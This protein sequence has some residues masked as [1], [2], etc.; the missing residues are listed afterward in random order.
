MKKPSKI[1]KAAPQGKSGG[2]AITSRQVPRSQQSEIGNVDRDPVELLKLN[3]ADRVERLVPLRYGRML[4]SP[5]AFFRGSAIIQAHDL[6]GTPDSGL[7]FQIC[8]DCHLANFGGFATPERRLLFDLND[9]DETSEAPWEWDIKRLV[10]QLRAGR[11]QPR[12]QGKAGRGTGICGLAQLSDEN[13]GL[14]RDEHSGNL[15]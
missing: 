12:V 4:A 15:V 11:A 7:V 14:R 13:A 3:S 8:G 9:F 2:G 6:A 1:E 10:R 5:F